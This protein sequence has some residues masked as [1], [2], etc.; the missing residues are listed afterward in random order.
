MLCWATKDSVA[1]L[2][3]IVAT[4]L[5]AWQTLAPGRPWG[6]AM[7]LVALI[8]ALVIFTASATHAEKR[9][10]LVIGNAAYVLVP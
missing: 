10:G 2:Q 5:C 3:A 8:F 9:V 1:T 4:A 6:R 7:R